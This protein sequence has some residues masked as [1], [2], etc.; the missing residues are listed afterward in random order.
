VTKS[1]GAGCTFEEVAKK[2]KCQKK[3][4]CESFYN[5]NSNESSH[6]VPRGQNPCG[7]LPLIC[8]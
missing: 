5:Q 6:L 8:L 7:V 3:A 1:L 2:I 4:E